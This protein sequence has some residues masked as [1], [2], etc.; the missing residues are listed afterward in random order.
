MWYLAYASN[1][2]RR[3]IEARVERTELRWMVACLDGYALQL[4]KGKKGG[5]AQPVPISVPFPA[6]PLRLPSPPP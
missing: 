4:N 1:M 2:N 5:V 3:Q 6:Q